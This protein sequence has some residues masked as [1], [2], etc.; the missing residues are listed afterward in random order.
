MFF[1]PKEDQSIRLLIIIG[2][3]AI[4]FAHVRA[5]GI[6][7]LPDPTHYASNHVTYSVVRICA[8]VNSIITPALIGTR[9]L[10]PLT[11]N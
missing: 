5:C 6:R 4:S 10:T 7:A 1:E 9:Y 11:V 2:A 3:C 8:C